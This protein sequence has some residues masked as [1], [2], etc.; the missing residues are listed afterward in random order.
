MT[1]EELRAAQ[2]FL[3]VTPAEAAEVL[4]TDVGTIRRIERAP[5]KSTARPPLAR[6]AQ[7]YRA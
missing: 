7:L 5:G 6:I 3:G 1:C 4:E 2:E